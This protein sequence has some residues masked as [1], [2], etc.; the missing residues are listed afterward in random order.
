[1][2]RFVDQFWVATAIV[3]R[4]V[5]RKNSCRQKA[6]AIWNWF[7]DQSQPGLILAT[8]FRLQQIYST[9]WCLVNQV[10][11]HWTESQR[12]SSV[13]N[14][15]QKLRPVLLVFQCTWW[16]PHNVSTDPSLSPPHLPPF[17]K[18]V[19]TCSYSPFFHS[20]STP[21]LRS[22]KPEHNRQHFPDSTSDPRDSGPTTNPIWFTTMSRRR[23]RE[24]ESGGV[25]GGLGRG[26]GWGIVRL[27]FN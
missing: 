2:S 8:N 6:K 12:C 9:T 5:K 22:C 20:A 14:S 10:K 23:R 16:T 7:E 11:P 17:T 3:W 24:S 21:P 26:R 18:E 25:G 19:E 4:C 15:Q 13:A 1:M 27:T